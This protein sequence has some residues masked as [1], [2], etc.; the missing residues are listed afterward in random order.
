MIATTPAHYADLVRSLRAW[1]KNLM[2]SGHF[3]AA[4]SLTTELDWLSHEATRT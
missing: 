2:C 3:N 1:I 4:N